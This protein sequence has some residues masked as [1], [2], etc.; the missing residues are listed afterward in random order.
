M[1]NF[2]ELKIWKDSLQLAHDIYKLTKSFPADERYGLVSQINRC[3]VSI[4]SN[5]AEGSS[6]KSSKEFER[7][8]EIALGSSFELE[9]QLLIAEKC[10]YVSDQTCNELIEKISNIQK[11]TFGFKEKIKEQ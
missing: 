7:F 11:M 2:K 4:P 1:H 3:S 6:R 10:G 8:L 9:T 5:I